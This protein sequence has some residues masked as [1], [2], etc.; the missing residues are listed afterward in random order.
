MLAERIFF[1]Y[2]CAAVFIYRAFC[3][4]LW[5][6]NS[7]AGA[8]GWANWV[9]WSHLQWHFLCSCQLKMLVLILRSWKHSQVG[10]FLYLI[11]NVSS[12]CALRIRGSEP[13]RWRPI[14][15]G[16]ISHQEYTLEFHK[17]HQTM[18]NKALGV[19]NMAYF[20]ECYR[21]QDQ[22]SVLQ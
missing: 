9:Y 12:V 11:A 3:T 20:C 4:F 2:K 17:H 6:N 5:S 7:M 18:Q 13:T 14:I 21:A 8:V 15:W 1:S 22:A 16:A 19:K 10:N